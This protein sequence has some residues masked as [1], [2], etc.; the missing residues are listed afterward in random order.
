MLQI[1]LQ[2]VNA[3]DVNVTYAQ[4]YSRTTYANDVKR[5]KFDA[6]RTTILNIAT[7]HLCHHIAGVTLRQEKAYVN[8]V[9][10]MRR[11]IYLI[12]VFLA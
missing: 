3:L 8:D 5:K 4:P 11:R 7:P 2:I 1:T 6:V 12:C 9:K 10:K